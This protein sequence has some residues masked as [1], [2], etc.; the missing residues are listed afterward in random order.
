MTG[1]G[2]IGLILIVANIV[3]SYK[4]FSDSLFF[5]RYKFE[6]DKILIGKDYKRLVTSGFL[7]I[8]WMHLIFNMLSLYFFSGVIESSLGGFRFLIIYFASMIGGEMFSMLVHKNN[9]DYS[10][11]GASGAICGIIF[12]SIALFPGMGIG[13]FFLPISI[14][15]W[16][17]GLVFVLYSI[18]AVQSKKDNVGH[19]MHL[20]GALVGMLTALLMEPSALIQNYPVILLIAVPT[21]AFIYFIITRPQILFIDNYFF[22]QHQHFTIDDRYNQDRHQQQMEIDRILEKISKRGMGSL[23]RSEKEKLKNYSEKMK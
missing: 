5:D 21:I 2:I 12:S 16:L 20:G 1:T 10:S 9:G 14:P 13:L 3:F 23:S 6:V 7:H 4:G 19:D 22:K 15:N 8:N 11:V 17:F 18:Y